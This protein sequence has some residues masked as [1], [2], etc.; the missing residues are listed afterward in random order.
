MNNA[1]LSIRQITILRNLINSQEFITSDQLAKSL[2]ISIR[3]LKN[4][5]T[6]IK[7][8]CA[9][10]KDLIFIAKASKGYK[11]NY[12]GATPLR[13]NYFLTNTKYLSNEIRQWQ[14][15]LIILNAQTIISIKELC[16]KFIVSHTTI[17]KDLKSLSK[18][19]DIYHVKINYERY[20]G[21]YILASE[22]NIRFAMQYYLNKFMM[23]DNYNDPY[24]FGNHTFTKHNLA[25][26]INSIA[27][28]PI[29]DFELTNLYHHLLII[30]M[31]CKH[32]FHL[33]HN[34]LRHSKYIDQNEIANTQSFLRS[35]LSDGINL[36]KTDIIFFILLYKGC[37]LGFCN[38]QSQSLANDSLAKL[39]KSLKIDFTT[40]AKMTNFSSY[41]YSLLIRLDNN[42]IQ[43]TILIDEIRQKDP[44]AYDIAYHFI[45]ILEQ[46]LKVTIP[47]N[48]ISYIAHLFVNIDD[49]LWP[50]YI[51]P[52]I[53]VVSYSGTII[54]QH[55]VNKLKM[56]YFQCQF[57]ACEFYDIQ[58]Q[59][60]K[61]EYALIL[62]DVNV[63]KLQ[64]PT[65][66]IN[67]FPSF[68]DYMHIS[69]YLLEHEVSIIKEYFAK[70]QLTK[71]HTFE[72]FIKSLK[73]SNDT[74]DFIIQRNQQLSYLIKDTAL[75][76]IY[77][78]NFNTSIYHAINGL[79]INGTTINYL[80]LINV[81]EKNQLINYQHIIDIYLKLLP[82]LAYN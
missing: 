20:H 24:L 82:N 36:N 30:L 17:Q 53:L 44:L 4:D 37:N 6:H 32:G 71:E 29:S 9:T 1:Y 48:E 62:S 60:K 77:D 38:E 26:F 35:H 46:E 8:Y 16:D 12:A 54:G 49:L 64:L 80:F 72:Q 57:S 22:L 13:P 43:N 68:D 69:K 63:G 58:Y 76:F 2:N 3:T 65:I 34:E 21:I 73:L 39:S 67:H 55:I 33:N 42:F 47:I 23:N 59:L 5:I 15:M 78:D 61:H 81:I 66:K 51:Q 70:K 56:H 19:L 11:V 18:Y 45:K 28:Q 40:L 74:K 75:I 27:L 50:Y 41:I 14:I 79:I 25:I 31:R 52:H 7:K 10:Q